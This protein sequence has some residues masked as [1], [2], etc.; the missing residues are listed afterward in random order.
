MPA[1]RKQHETTEYEKA[2]RQFHKISSRHVLVMEADLDEDQKRRIFH[3][4]ELARKLGNQLTGIMQK[5]LDQLMR[6]KKYRALKRDYRKATEAS[7]KSDA[8]GTA[9]ERMKMIGAEMSA[10]QEEYQVTWESL[11]L[12]M[13]GLA[14][15]TAGPVNSVFWLTAAEDV[16]CGVEKVLYGNGEH[17]HFRKRGDLPSLRAKQT[18][19]ALIVKAE[20]GRLLFSYNGMKFHAMP[21]DRFVR[22]EVEAVLAYMADLDL[23]DAN[24]VI[25]MWPGAVPDDTFRPCYATLV[26]REIR[27]KLRVYIHLT[28]EGRAMPKY[29]K[30]GSRRH[31]YGKGNV[32]CDIGT[33]TI[34]WTSGTEVGLINLA[35]RGDSI[36]TNERAQ[37]LA[38]RAMDRS[39]RATNPG[40]YREDGTIRKG[41]KT[42]LKSKRYRKLQARHAE[43]ARKAAENRRCAINEDVNH[44]RSLGDVFITEPK[45]AKKLQK[46]AG[47]KGKAEVSKKTGR[48]KRKKRFGKSIR[49]RCP[50][51]FQAKA[52]QVFSATGAYHEVPSGYRASQYDHTADDYI[53]KKL[54]DRM[55]RLADGTLVQR[56][57]YSSFLL[58]SADSAYADIDRQK[59]REEFER[60]LA[61]EHKL[62]DHIKEARIRIMNSG[63]RAAG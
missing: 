59:C 14:P 33:Q 41:K 5:R 39:R 22:D 57:W 45:N 46:R 2:L 21:G 8:S 26:C 38:Y 27:R 7:K 12:S 32:G 30:D 9:K 11:R 10:M 51:Y 25:G 16:W 6:T 60:K 3:D 48:P 4:A 52:Q 29:H 24:A 31:R 54:S 43:A 15:K 19:G 13:Q 35:E 34:A 42:W 53:K 49:N 20:G 47:K 44:L 58:Y 37:R 1:Q 55:Y 18:S 17:L 61:M 50:G 56:D 36:W 40:N 62:I 63:I 23:A 28:I